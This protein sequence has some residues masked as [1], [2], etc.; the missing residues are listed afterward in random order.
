MHAHSVG[1]NHEKFHQKLNSGGALDAS[2]QALYGKAAAGEDVFFSFFQCFSLLSRERD[3]A[4]SLLVVAFV[5]T[6][7]PKKRRKRTG[8]RKKSSEKHVVE[9]AL[10][11]HGN[12]D[13]DDTAVGS[14]S[15]AR[16]KENAK[17]KKDRTIL[18]DLFEDP[19]P[20]RA[21]LSFWRW[22]RRGNPPN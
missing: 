1:I 12:D 15:L 17:R 22:T 3:D 7:L 14:F 5:N 18:R 10:F 4:F 6:R 16:Q 9:F 11:I 8:K 19:L 20:R 13:D 2:E 21:H